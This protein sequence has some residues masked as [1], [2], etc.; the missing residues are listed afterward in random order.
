MATVP[1]DYASLPTDVIG[2]SESQMPVEFEGSGQMH[3]IRTVR[4]RQGVSLRT[5][6]RQMGSTIRELRK[7]EEE[8]ADLTVS[9]LHQWQ[10]ALEVP[11]CEMLVEPDH[12]ALS[13]PILERARLLRM[14]KTA[15]SLRE[16]ASDPGQERLAENLVN[17]LIEIM[18]ELK[19]IAPWHT[20]GQRRS[21][22]EVGRV[23]EQP[24]ALAVFEADS[25]D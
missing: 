16:E 14:M 3:R 20:Y 10:K 23:A 5:A 2:T 21:L 17:Q 6:A 1:F 8:T 15:Q 24:V 22:D 11:I 9:Q 13:P 12:S 4:L 18:P 7:Q 25:W 19:D